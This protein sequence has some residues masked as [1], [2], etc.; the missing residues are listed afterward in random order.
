M[1]PESVASQAA[2]A[3]RV[4][5]LAVDRARAGKR[6]GVL[7]AHGANGVSEVVKARARRLADLGYVAFALDYVG[8]GAVLS[9]IDESRARLAKYLDAP[10]RIREIGRASLDLLR[11]QPEVDPGKIA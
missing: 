7:I 3:R 11:A 8:D 2:G 1:H 4:G 6:P 10:E 5:Y 9:D